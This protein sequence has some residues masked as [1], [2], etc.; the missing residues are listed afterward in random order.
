MKLFNLS[1]EK[2]VGAVVFR[3]SENGEKEFLLLH[4]PS[5]HWDFPKGH[6]EKGEI[7][8]QTLRREVEEET[9]IND[10][11][12][13]SGFRDSIRYF[14]NAKGNERKDR[15]LSK[16]GLNIFKK[17]IYYLTET[18]ERDIKISHEHI[19]SGWFSY[20]NTMN[21]LA[22]EN[23]KRIMRKAGEFLSKTP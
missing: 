13:T 19:G 16:S 22:H 14:Y 15:M 6:V 21:K 2:S 17:V 12:I 1:F 18:K 9:G 7:E 3:E 20:E 11:I 10:L 8:E 5:G 23:G 4:Y